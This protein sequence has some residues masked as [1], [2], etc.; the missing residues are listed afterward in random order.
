MAPNFSKFV[1]RNNALAAGGAATAAV[2]ILLSRKRQR[3]LKLDRRKVKRAIDE[4]VKYFI[5]EKKENRVKAQ[6]DKQFLK[7]LGQLLKIIVPGWT[8]PEAG[9]LFLVALSLVTRSV[10]DLWMIDNG[11]KI[12]S[13]I[14]S[15]DKQLFKK[16]LLNFVIALPIISVM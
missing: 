8:S 11:T 2:W 12:E 6:V 7:Q 10:C 9:F 3:S 1:S 5:S 14:V 16:R 15:M 4:E 13:A